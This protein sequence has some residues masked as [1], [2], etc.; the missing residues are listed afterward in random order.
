MPHS[1]TRLWHPFA[2]MHAV[3]SAELVIVRGEGAYVLG[4]RGPPLP[5]R[6][7]QPLV[8]QRRPRPHARSPTP[9]PRRCAS[10]R[11]YSCFGAFAN[12]P[13]LELAERLG[14]LAPVDDAR[15]FFGQRRRRR[16]RHRRQ[17]RPPLLRRH[18]AARARAP[19]LAAAQGYHGTHGFGTSIGGI[20]ANRAGCG[21][22]DPNASQ[23]PHD[24]LEALEA[25]IERVGRRARRGGVRRAG[26]RRGRRPP[27]G[28]GYIEGVA[29]LCRAHGVLLVVDA[30]ICGFGR[31]GHVVRRPSA[32]ASSPT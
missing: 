31:L 20:P 30:V 17:A 6:H 23:V 3:R 14:E 32:W 7:R 5:R 28:P 10:S 8:R 11:R 12:Q 19:D 25:E 2:D 29:E 13:A 18:R 21:P 24:S 9:S 22:L 4:R 16:D 26:D 27:A 1:D 15:V